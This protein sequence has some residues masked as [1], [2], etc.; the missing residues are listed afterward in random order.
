M[1]LETAKLV[2]G[3]ESPIGE[4]VNAAIRCV[5]ALRDGTRRAAILKRIPH[6]RVMAECFCA[7]LLRGWGLNVPE[8]FLVDEGASIAFGS[9]DAAYPSLTQRFGISSLPDSPMK[10]A[11]VNAAIQ[12]VVS[13]VQT[14]LATMADEAIDN[15]DRN[16][17]NVLWDGQ[18]ET[19]IDHELALG[20][21]AHFPD[22][23]KLAWMAANTPQVDTVKTSAVAAWMAVDRGVVDTAG[24]A[25]NCSGFAG[26]VAQRL[27]G[28]GT[29]ILDRFPSPNDL[30][31]RQ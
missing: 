31:T 30:L 17:G 18:S 20:L 16:L 14:P 5:L 13:F 10:D 4:G 3:S 6:E 2:A 11:L 26:L 28:L 1:K 9:A 24:A 21:G 15:R 19:W 12:L 29:R 23:N 22:M 27:N 7:L 8:P 25:S